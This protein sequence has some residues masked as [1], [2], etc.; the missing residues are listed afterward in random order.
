LRGHVAAMAFLPLIT[1][2][3]MLAVQ[4]ASASVTSV[5]PIQKVLSMM[6]DMKSKGI[7]SKQEEEVRFGAF[8]QFCSG[9]SAAKQK[10]IEN[11]AATIEKLDAD[12]SKASSDI[13]G[14]SGDLSELDEDLGRWDTDKKAATDVRKKER[15]DYQATH[16]D[17]ADTLDAVERAMAT[18]K[19]MPK[20]INQK[21]FIQTQLK[22]VAK[23]TAMQGKARRAFI[24]MIATVS[25]P[26]DVQNPSAYA[27]ESQSDGVIK[28]LEDLRTRF[29]GEKSAL[30]KEEMMNRA[31][32]QSIMQRLTDQIE[33]AEQETS[34]KTKLR[35]TRKGDKAEAEG[36]MKE[37]QMIKAEDE[38][39]LSDLTSL[40][41]KKSSDFESRQQLRAGE[42]DALS[43]A[44]EIIGSDA[45]KGSGEKHLPSA[46]LA[47]QAA[48]AQLRSSSG[49]AVP[50][51]CQ[52]VAALLAERAQMFHSPVLALAAQ[53]AQNDPFV[54]VR[55]MIK[56]LLVKLMEEAAGESDHK[57]F[58]DA[59]LATNKKTRTYKAE[60]V[61][62]LT[63]EVEKQT[64]IS[65]K[66]GADIADLSAEISELEAAMAKSSSERQE[67][68]TLNAATV[69]DAKEAQTAVAQALAVLR[70]FYAKAAE[71]TALVQKSHRGPADDAPETF[72]SAYTGQGS[73]ST[74]VVGMLEVIE[75]DFARLQTATETA[76]D[77]AVSAYK[78]FM[79]DSDQDKAVKNTEM[80]HKENK[81]TT[82]EELLVSTKRSLDQTQTELDAA[83]QYYDK[84]KP[85][86]V[87][88]GVSYEERVQ[89]RKEEL[90]SLQDAYKIIAGEDLPSLSDMK[91]EQLR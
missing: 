55:K 57:A 10:A 80:E 1:T 86:C 49:S 8:Q 5:T 82:T 69:A 21:S 40:C 52:R 56:D 4:E 35:A 53:K 38:K 44:I 74:G 67:E 73:T 81:R 78:K 91:S 76:E 60:D 77:E 66:L 50:S 89:K 32:Y 23:E 75:S 34:Q 3:T 26:L 30:E 87:D 17:Y 29:R 51:D 68:K 79:A 6:E 83:L 71:A 70:E 37:T 33:L 88:S 85:D 15:A 45:V 42:I 27:Y 24:A 25:D 9:T 36:D 62:E 19:S 54:K 22:S 46:A 47:Q 16:T 20:N 59:E 11:G 12:I 84:L 63:A 43:K 18:I 61:E 90:V 31:A 14:L 39:Y 64:A 48:F 2:M 72:D 13:A 65:A 58:C 7:K 28:M 41:A